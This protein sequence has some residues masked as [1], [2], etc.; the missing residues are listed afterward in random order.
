MPVPESSFLPLIL[1]AAQWEGNGGLGRCSTQRKP[2]L[3]YIP[4]CLLVILRPKFSLFVKE[5]AFVL[6]TD[7]ETFR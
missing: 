2:V 1:L 6:G 4:K 3:T 5:D 7:I